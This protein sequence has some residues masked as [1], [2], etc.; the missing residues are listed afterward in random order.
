MRMLPLICTLK[1][2]PLSEEDFYTPRRTLSFPLGRF[3]GSK[4]QDESARTKAMGKPYVVENKKQRKSHTHHEVVEKRSIGKFG[5]FR[6]IFRKTRSLPDF[7]ASLP[8]TNLKEKSSPLLGISEEP[9][10]SNQT[11]DTKTMSYF[12]KLGLSESMQKPV[13][14][15]EKY[16][17]PEIPPAGS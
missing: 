12:R 13:A 11:E 14:S 1:S 5:S 15:L 2:H 9:V 4:H 10:Y 7:E 17:Y 3:L 6:K 16:A 8:S